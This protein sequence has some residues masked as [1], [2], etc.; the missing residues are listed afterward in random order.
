MPTLKNPPSVWTDGT[1]SLLAQGYAWLPDHMRAS[2]DGTVRT[3]LLGRRTVALRGPEAVAFFYDEQHVQRRAALPDPVLDTLFG[4]GA[5][6]TLDG[7]AHRVRKAMFLSLLKDDKGI[8]ALREHVLLRWREAVGRWREEPEESVVLFDET[9]RVLALAVCDWTGV[10]VTGAGGAQLAR[11]CVAMVDGFATA[12]PR[13]LRARHARKRQEEALGRLVAR[14][15][16]QRETAPDGSALDVVARHRDADG[17]VL[18]PRPA[19]VE[20]LN[21]IRPTVAIAWFVTFAAHA[22]HRWP[23]HRGP[24]RGDASGHLATGFAHEVRRFYPFAPFVGGLAARDLQWR[25]EIVPAG[26]LLLLDLYG[27]HHDPQL[28]AHPYRFDPHRYAAGESLRHLI[29]QGGGDAAE[30]HRCPG[31]DITVTLLTALVTELAGL[32]VHVPDQ[33]LTIPLS[34]MPTL[35]RSGFRLRLA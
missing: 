18:D 12:G 11:D 2:A 9:A 7:L 16:E 29:P 14:V 22:L 17:A 30:G 28:W 13:H 24:L 21:I 26:T 6:H 5:V 32:D 8:E 23:E 4:Q 31:E 19:A 34:R 27:Q 35:P 3:R 10:P 20:L 15:R 33:D 25:G 1:L